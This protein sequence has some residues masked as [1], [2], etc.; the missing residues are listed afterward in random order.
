MRLLQVVCL[1]LINVSCANTTSDL[2]ITSDDIAKF[3]QVKYWKIPSHDES[4]W[5]IKVEDIPNDSIIKYS[6]QKVLKSGGVLVT[7]QR[8]DADEFRCSMFYHDEVVADNFQLHL[9]SAKLTWF[10]RPKQIEGGK[11]ILGEA[12]GNWPNNHHVDKLIVI[13]SVRLK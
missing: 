9:M 4:H 10:D 5:A 11:Y 7:I 3:L 1:I 6:S 13:Q 8:V 12:I 2:L